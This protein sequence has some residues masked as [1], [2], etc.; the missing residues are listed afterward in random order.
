MKH[1]YQCMV[2]S[3]AFQADDKYEE[4]TGNDPAKRNC[5][6]CKNAKG[7]IMYHGINAWVQPA[8]NDKLWD[9]KNPADGKVYDSKSS[10]YKALKQSGSHVIEAG[11][12]HSSKEIKGDYNVRKE[13]TQ[14]VSRYL[15]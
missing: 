14:A 4:K 15:N 9:V 13:L 10:Y 8:T 7:R 2:C 11:E 6:K 3:H 1:S 5:P 12:K